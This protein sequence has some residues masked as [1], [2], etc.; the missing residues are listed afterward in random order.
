MRECTSQEKESN[1]LD[2]TRFPN[3]EKA[4]AQAEFTMEFSA[5][6]TEQSKRQ[7]LNNQLVK[8]FK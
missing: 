8:V 4:K 6:Q 3:E 2:L 5:I 7:I 1:V